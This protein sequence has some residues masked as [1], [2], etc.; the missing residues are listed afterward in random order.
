MTDDR[1]FRPYRSMDRG[2]KREFKRVGSK[3][4]SFVDREDQHVGDL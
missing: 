4:V 1:A 3:R 2:T